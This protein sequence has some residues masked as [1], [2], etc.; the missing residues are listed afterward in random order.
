M[1]NRIIL[2]KLLFPILPYMSHPS[3]APPSYLYRVLLELYTSLTKPSER[4]TV[5]SPLALRTGWARACVATTDRTIRQSFFTGGTS[6]ETR[7][8]EKCEKIVTKIWGINQNSVYLWLFSQLHL[9]RKPSFQPRMRQKRRPTQIFCHQWPSL[10][11]VKLFVMKIVFVIRKNT[12][13]C[14]TS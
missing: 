11:Q 13:F 12:S 8:S 5:N 7:C 4:S 2:I 3:N 10:T 9:L 1:K 14:R 6:S